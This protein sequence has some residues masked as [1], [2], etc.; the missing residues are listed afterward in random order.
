MTD[1]LLESELFG[2][3]KG[4]FTGAYQDRKGLFE[5]AD[6]GT[7]FLDEIGDM[8]QAMQAKLLRALQE[9][10]IRPVGGKQVINV[11]VRIISATNKDLKGAVGQGRF[12]EDLFYRLNGVTIQLPPL[13]ER[14]E[15]VALLADYFLH[16]FCR[17]SGIGRK[18]LSQEV[19]KLLFAYSWP[20][21]VREL[22]NTI[23]HA[24]VI[25]QGETINPEDF[26]Y[27]PE[28]FEGIGRNGEGMQGPNGANAYS[29]KADEPFQDG[30]RNIEGLDRV[31]MRP[32]KSLKQ[33]ERDTIENALSACGG[34]RREAARVL[35]IPIRTLYEKIKRY[36]IE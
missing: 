25:S 20:G 18:A 35:N 3:V 22:E 21:N 8:S 24:C 14:R 17:E 29:N 33:T 26:R 23:K 19:Q 4:S 2:H 7:L 15:D 1:T 5:E 28:L 30:N 6:Q 13:R 34:R 16:S 32:I 10:E 31:G 12:R 27:K 11:D 36:G 9:G